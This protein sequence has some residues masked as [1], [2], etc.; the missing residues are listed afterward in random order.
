MSIVSTPATA[1]A[2][3]FTRYDTASRR[4]LSAV[5]GGANVDAGA[6]VAQ[7]IEAKHQL[8]AAVNT[9]RIGDEMFK[10]LIQIGQ[11]R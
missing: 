7:Q 9:V 2:N 11:T 6:A 10:A 4:L 3:A 8:Q 5:Q 1:I